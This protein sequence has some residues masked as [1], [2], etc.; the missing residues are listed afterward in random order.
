MTVLLAYRPSPEGDA[1][2]A[3]AVD[4]A[5]ARDAELVVVHSSRGGRAETEQFVAEIQEAGFKM[6]TK[7]TELGVRH[8]LA[9]IVVGDSP[10]RDVV[11]VA[12]E[13]GADLLVI[14]LRNRSRVGKLLLGSDAQEILLT[15]P[16]PVLAVK[17]RAR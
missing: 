15:A 14:G 1:A 9:E 10:A 8:R 11:R 4:A 3:A 7:L 12:D 5:L 6:E 17:A 2:F 16:C 13:I